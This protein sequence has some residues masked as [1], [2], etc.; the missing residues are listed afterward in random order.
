MIGFDFGPLVKEHHSQATLTQLELANLAG[1]GKPLFLIL[2]KT[3]KPY[4]ETIRWQY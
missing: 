1:E 3:K 2:K 4:V